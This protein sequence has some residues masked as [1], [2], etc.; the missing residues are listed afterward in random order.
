MLVA[1][2]QYGLE[3]IRIFP[4]GFANTSQIPE[5][6]KMKAVLIVIRTHGESIST[7]KKCIVA[8]FFMS[9]ELQEVAGEGAHVVVQT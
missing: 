8:G 4:Y 6:T 7:I 1:N 9:H 5:T 2:L 3:S